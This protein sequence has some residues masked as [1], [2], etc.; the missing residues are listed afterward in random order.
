[1][2]SLKVQPKFPNKV[3][4][5][6]FYLYTRTDEPCANYI[7]GQDDP[8]RFV[9]TADYILKRRPQIL[10]INNTWVLSDS[11]VM[12]LRFGWTRFPD[13][14]S[15]SIH[16]DPASLGF[17][18]DF[19]GEVGRTGGPKLPALTGYRGYGHQDPVKDRV[20]KSW[21]FNGTYSKFVGTHTYKIGA[22]FRQIGGLLDSTSCP[23]GCLYFGREFTSST[24]IN[25]SSATDGNAM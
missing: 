23:S 16:F 1:L 5:T 10:A 2:H 7:A 11:S 3:A 12:A 8:N 6:G 4:L 25:N 20:Y 21:G 24:G 15:L 17:S 18:P 13:N 19:A 22:D 9:D 14:P